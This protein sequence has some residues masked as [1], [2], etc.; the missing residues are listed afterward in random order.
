MKRMPA[1]LPQSKIGRKIGQMAD[2][3]LG[4]G[5]VLPGRNAPLERSAFYNVLPQESNPNDKTLVCLP[6]LFKV[7][8]L[9][10]TSR[11]LALENKIKSFDNK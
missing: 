11:R 9:G 1:G 7:G 4:F 6:T 5:R 10:P 3:L 8:L 2:S